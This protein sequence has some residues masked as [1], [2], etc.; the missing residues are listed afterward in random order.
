MADALALAR[1]EGGDRSSRPSVG[2]AFT[3]YAKRIWESRRVPVYPSPGS[4]RPRPSP[5]LPR[6]ERSSPP[7]R[8]LLP[9]LR[10]TARK[11]PGP[12][13]ATSAKPAG[14]PCSKTRPRTCPCPRLFRPDHFTAQ[15]ADEAVRAANTLTYSVALKVL[16]PDIPHKTDAGGVRLGQKTSEDARRPYGEMIGI[17]RAPGAGRPI[18][19]ALSSSRWRTWDWS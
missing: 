19:G 16:S 6:E 10:S 18:H 4:G 11:R 14:A 5:R 17:R 8:P 7:A 1:A 3:Q 9:S 15:D 13:S 2:G 12:P